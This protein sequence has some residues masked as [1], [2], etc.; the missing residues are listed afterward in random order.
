MMKGCVYMIIKENLDIMEKLEILSD[1]AKYDVSCSSSGVDRKNNGK[2]IGNS[3]ACGICHS[4]SA[5]GRCI[6]LLKIL[7]TNE[8]IYNCKYCVNR[9]SNDVIRAT[10]T[11]EEIC[12]LTM[13]FYKRNYIEGLFLSS[14]VIISP[15]ETMKR[16]L[17][18]VV[19][20]RTKYNFG[21]Y[22]HMKA[23]PGAS[24][25]IINMAGWYVDRMSV[26]LELPTN[27]G[28]K[29]LAPSKTRE[30]ILKPMKSIQQ[31]I[32]YNRIELKEANNRLISSNNNYSS[33]MY[34][35]NNEVNDF[36]NDSIFSSN[37]S[38][39]F[40]MPEANSYALK[41]NHKD[42]KTFVPA[43]QS[44]QMIIGATDETDY[45]LVTIAEALYKKYD[46]K[47]VFYSAFV[48]VNKDDTLPIQESDED[49][50]L[51]REHRLYQADWLMR[52][53]GFEA[54]DLLS[55]D[56]PNFNAFLDPKCDWAVRHLEMFP[57]EINKASYNTLLKVPGI[58]VKSARRIVF[59]RKNANLDF[60]DLK[61][62]GVVLK[63]ALYF[64][65]CN[66]KMMYN[67]KIDEDYITASLIYS[68]KRKIYDTEHRGIY[69]QLSL[70]DA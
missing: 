2:G 10:F 61:K 53:Y 8:C 16:L 70:F 30:S 39:D 32:N 62:V 19:L 21:G 23:I 20:L 5:D 64:I 38:Y 11:P 26:N 41:N 24:D 15:D 58:G 56:K 66:G 9:V 48:N 65:T 45:H 35:I 60:N 63:R 14:G 57:V 43:G 47:R 6:S 18:T 29:R 40:T 34:N 25:D 42:I 44:S 52:F 12:K 22:I 27:E 7:M 3:K 36:S 28:L 54:S 49:V 69:K 50:P 67:T 4:F 51:L 1:A 31:G 68:N 59:A 37:N 33:N 46:L 17:Q 13:Q 55:E